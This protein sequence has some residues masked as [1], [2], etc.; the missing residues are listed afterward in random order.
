M[1]GADDTLSRIIWNTLEA[2]RIVW[3][4][5]APLMPASS[6]EAL[7]RLGANPDE[8]GADALRWGV[9]AAGAPVRV[10]D[11]IFPRIDAA[12]YM[13]ASPASASIISSKSICASPKCVPPKR[14][15]SRR[16]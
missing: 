8:I 9:L 12:T 4:M 5:V 2:L 6:R 7:S 11:P 3:V 13:P 1:P 16:S 15:R 10:T 14:W